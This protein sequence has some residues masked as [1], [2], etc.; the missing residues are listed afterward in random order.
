[1]T[2]LKRS[3]ITAMIHNKAGKAPDLPVLEDDLPVIGYEKDA[4]IGYGLFAPFR[5]DREIIR[6]KADRRTPSTG[7]VF[8]RTP[9]GIPD[10][11]LFAGKATIMPELLQENMAGQHGNGWIPGCKKFTPGELLSA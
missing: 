7:P 9:V 4:V 2:F 6:L 10:L 5:M 11:D 8:R 1:M 3:A